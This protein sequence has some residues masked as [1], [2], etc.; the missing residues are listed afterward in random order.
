MD[1]GGST[2]TVLQQ[3]HLQQLSSYYKVN[4]KKMKNKKFIHIFVAKNISFSVYTCKQNTQ[5]KF[6]K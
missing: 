2:R 4:K 6:Q 5:L 1:G 3:E